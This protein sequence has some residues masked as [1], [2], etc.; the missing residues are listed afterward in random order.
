MTIP[1]YLRHKGKLFYL[2]FSNSRDT[3]QRWYLF[4]FFELTRVS[5]VDNS[6]PDLLEGNY[7]VDL[8]AFFIHD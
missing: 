5:S 8:V 6:P 3:N 7:V 1:S 2:I 4:Q